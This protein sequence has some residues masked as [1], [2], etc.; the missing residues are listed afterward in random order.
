LKKLTLA[1]AVL[2]AFS[3]AAQAESNWYASVGAASVNPNDSSSHLNVV[4]SVAGLPANSTEA[5][6]DS[7]TQ[8]GLTL[9]YR[10][11]PSWSIELLAATPFSHD[12]S[13][14][15]SAIDGLAIGDV[16]HLP[17]TLTAKYHFNFDNS[18]WGAFI[19]AGV[20]YTMFFDDQASPDL[21][22]TL[23]TLNVTTAS[24]EVDLK[25]SN[26]WGVA[27]QAGLTYKLNQD[28][29]V[30]GNVWYM[31]IDTDA[32][33]RVNGTAIQAVD[34]EIDPTVYYLGLEYQF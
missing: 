1:I 4:E 13:V 6:V 29:S 8:L 26:S 31:D 2:S 5:Q 28:W 27:L 30:R 22:S 33:V 14:K 20:N 32:E 16:K 9:G 17:P 15:G 18:N 24:D 10:L 12:V 7:N 25:L 3:S 19:G 21:V 11:N 34:V 23:Q